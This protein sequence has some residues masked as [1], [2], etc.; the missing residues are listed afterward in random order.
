MPLLQAET[1]SKFYALGTNVVH[2]LREVSFAIDAAEMVAIMG[3]SGSGKSTM[4][5]L[6]GCLDTPTEGVYRLEGVN[7][8]DLTKD[9]LAETRNRRIGFVFQS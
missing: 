4:M 1:L 7:V 3:P 6:L 8:A 2:A 5:D 9:A